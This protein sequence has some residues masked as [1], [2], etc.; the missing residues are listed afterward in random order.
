MEWCHVRSGVE[1]ASLHVVGLWTWM[2]T[3]VRSKERSF[4]IPFHGSV[5]VVEAH[6]MEFII[7]LKPCTH[8]IE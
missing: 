5:C 2:S 4:M 8:P 1:A 6:Q 7:M 3:L